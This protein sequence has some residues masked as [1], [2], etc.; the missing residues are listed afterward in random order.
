MHLIVTK[1]GISLA[2][3]GALRLK[4]NHI[5][6]FSYGKD[7]VY[8]ISTPCVKRFLRYRVRKKP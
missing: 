2:I 8:Q 7:T 6:I 5:I 3:F 4:V 1:R